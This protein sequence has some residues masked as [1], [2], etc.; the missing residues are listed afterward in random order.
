MVFVRVCKGVGV[1]EGY[2]YATTP[3]RPKAGALIKALTAHHRQQASRLNAHPPPRST[4]LQAQAPCDPQASERRPEGEGA[5]ES[6]GQGRAGRVAVTMMEPEMGLL[7]ASFATGVGPRGGGE[8]E[9]GGA[10]VTKRREDQGLRLL[11]PFCGSG[12][13]LTAAR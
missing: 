4:A 1:G 11:D 5:Q 9:V 13:L 2:L 7:M 6:E 3:R 8:D 12:A 10:R